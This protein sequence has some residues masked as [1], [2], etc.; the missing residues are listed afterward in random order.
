MSFV[1]IADRIQHIITKTMSHES[2]ILESYGGYMMIDHISYYWKMM[3]TISAH[4]VMF[5]GSGT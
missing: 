4:E 2:K 5:F 1:V 3:F